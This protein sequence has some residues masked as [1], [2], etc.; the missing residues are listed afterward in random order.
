MRFFRGG[1]RPN[2]RKCSFAPICLSCGC[3]FR[4]FVNRGTDS[5][6]S[7]FRS[8]RCFFFVL[9]SYFILR[10]IRD[11]VAVT[12][13]VTRLP[14]LFAGTLVAMLVA[15]PLF[16]SLVVR[17]PVRRFVPFTYQFFAANLVVFYF[18]MRGTASGQSVGAPWVG[19][20]FYIWTSVFNLF[21]T[22]VFW[23]LM[24]DVFRSEQAKRLFGFIGVGGTL[25]SITGSA[26]TA[27]LA[28]RLGTVNLFLVSVALLEIAPLI[29]IRFPAAPRS[30]T[31]ASAV[32]VEAPPIGGSVWAGITSLMRSN[33]GSSSE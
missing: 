7:R 11:L 14:W 3:C 9:S 4:R 29:V 18:I 24:A 12:T 6:A 25:G 31:D 19:V 2:S 26:V 27:V 1:S 15:N 17:F 32:P 13:G 22:S 16:A 5:P 28:Q 21:I 8:L 30:A 20:V 33:V 23:C 10:P